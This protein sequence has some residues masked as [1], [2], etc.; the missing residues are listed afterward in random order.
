M[1][2]GLRASAWEARISLECCVHDFHNC[3]VRA[4]LGD[5]VTLIFKLSGKM[6]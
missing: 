5:F 6:N 3:G 2:D 4:D 1:R